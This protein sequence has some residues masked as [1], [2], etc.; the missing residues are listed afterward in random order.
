VV[1]ILTSLPLQTGK[2][3]R[4]EKVKLTKASITILV[5][6]EEVRITLHDE[7]ASA[8]FAEIK[9]TPGQFT[10]ALSRLCNVACEIEVK[11][12]E[13]LNKKHENIYHVFEF[14]A[15][16]GFRPDKEKLYDLA[17]KTAPEGWTPD[18]YFSS[19]NTFFEKDGKRFCRVTIR[20]WV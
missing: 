3:D 20:R 4:G 17:C 14:P 7:T 5:E 13:K 1:G 19:Q 9:L 6:R 12:L 8:N 15:E 11:E 10:A 16:W 2:R 18:N